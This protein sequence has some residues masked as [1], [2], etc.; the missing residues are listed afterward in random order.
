MLELW[1]LKSRISGR[2]SAN[3]GLGELLVFGDGI[4]EF[5]DVLRDGGVLMGA[6][7]DGVA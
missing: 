3:L 1:F 4:V 5:I 7:E 2:R 6:L